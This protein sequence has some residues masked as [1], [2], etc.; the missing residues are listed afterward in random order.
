[1]NEFISRYQPQLSGVLAGFDRLVF[2]GQLALNHDTGRKGY[3]WANG[4]AW[5]DYAQHVAQVS[6]RVKEASLVPMNAAHR[7]VRYLS[8]GH[9]SKEELARESARLQTWFPFTL[10]VYVNGR[11]WLARQMDAA[12][13]A[14]N[15][16]DNCFSW[17]QDFAR[18]QALMDQQLTTDWRRALNTS[19]SVFIR[20]FPNCS[21]II[22]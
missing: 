12:G 5:K 17:I 20:C 8:N 19:P 15:R 18:A 6:Q 22:Q 10:Y 9:D 2:R 1:M 4:I 16:H 11:E 7:P 3:L 21:R 14:Y 13:I